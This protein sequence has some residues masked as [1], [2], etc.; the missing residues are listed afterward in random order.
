M[1]MPSVDT[2]MPEDQPGQPSAQAQVIGHG[3]LIQQ[4][5]ETIAAD[6]DPRSAIRQAFTLLAHQLLQASTNQT[7]VRQFAS[8]LQ[9]H[10]EELAE[11]CVGEGSKAP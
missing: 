1:T 2:P 8:E 7:L 10:A 4:I 11:L 5:R 9:Q 3:L 6:G